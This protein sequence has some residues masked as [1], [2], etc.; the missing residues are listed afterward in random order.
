LSPLYETKAC[1][2]CKREGH[3]T[4]WCPEL[5]QDKELGPVKLTGRDWYLPDG[6]HIPWNPSR[7]I[8]TVGAT[9]PADPQMQEAAKKLAEA[10]RTGKNQAPTTMKASAQ[11]IDWDPL[12]LGADNFLAN[13]TITRSEGQRKKR[14]LD[15]RARKGHNG[16]QSRRWDCWYYRRI[17]QNTCGRESV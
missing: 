15:L 6:Q 14:C 16:Y 10:H 2:Y 17:T 12:Q 3:T 5:A 13:H 11:N 1:C 4:Y 7:P 8:R 9:A